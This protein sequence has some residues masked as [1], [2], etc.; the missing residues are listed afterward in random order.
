MALFVILLIAIVVMTSNAQDL[1]FNQAQ[2]DELIELSL[3]M[4]PSL[5][6]AEVAS[7][8]AQLALT[9]WYYGGFEKSPFDYVTEG[10]AGFCEVLMF[11]ESQGSVLESEFDDMKTNLKGSSMVDIAKERCY[12][13]AAYIEIYDPSESNYF[14]VYLILFR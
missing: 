11:D 6:E 8:E 12:V 3:S 9:N 14:G 13:G 1:V 2:A 5:E 4:N 7:V 10:Y